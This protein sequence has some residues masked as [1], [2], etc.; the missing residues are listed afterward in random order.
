MSSDNRLC[1]FAG[2]FF[3]AE[4]NTLS[5][6]VKSFLAEA[7]NRLP[8]DMSNP[9]GIIS[10]HA[11]FRFSGSTAGLAYQSA[12][13]DGKKYKRLIVLSPSHRYAFQGMAL[14]SQ[15]S[16]SS[17]LGKSEL[18]K[19]GCQKLLKSGLTII[20][21]Q[22]HDNEHGIE[23][24]LPFIHQLW[25]KAKLI[26]LV[27]GQ[28][29][30]ENIEV[31]FEL[32][33]EDIMQGH[34]LVVISTDLS[35]FLKDKLAIEKDL[36]TAQM[37]ENFKSENI[38]SSNVCGHGPLKG[39]LKYVRKYGYR[40]TR[41]GMINSANISGDKSKVVGYG[42]WHFL[43][44]DKALLP[45]VHREKLITVARAS[46]EFYL[47][48]NKKPKIHT[49]TFHPTLRSMGATFV[50]LKEKGRL[51]GCIGTTMPNFSLVESVGK[52]A[53]SAAFN[54]KRFK[55]VTMDELKKLDIG[56]SILSQPAPLQFENEKDLL[57][58]IKPKE[59]G[60]ILST[61]THRGLFL[62]VVWESL[63][64]VESFWRGLKVK[65]G[66]PRDFWSGDLQVEYFKAEEFSD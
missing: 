19:D 12:Y 53:I 16:F 57:Q 56:I 50:S 48:K 66:L 27:I 37:I 6:M 21:N 15:K 44:A 25:P 28:E 47:S 1:A 8:G 45:Q 26:P 65:A 39:Y 46:I 14:P 61:P 52:N 62:P 23:T 17:P 64:D 29:R 30:I 40:A 55:P 24:Q 49:Q 20:S 63:N 43:H 34:T 54:D 10:P 33:H 36:Q 11:G 7:S 60:L 38:N 2:K 18:C 4:K 41:L 5:A 32:F 3:P 22:A 31:I 35:H 9:M 59:H 13:G 51:R 58:Q 42:A